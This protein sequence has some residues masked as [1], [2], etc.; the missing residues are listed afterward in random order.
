MTA[1]S[2]SCA[3]PIQYLIQQKPCLMLYGARGVGKS[4]VLNEI[5]PGAVRINLERFDELDRLSEDPAGFLA[6]A[7]GITII[8][9]VHHYPE[10]ADILADFL[11]LLPDCEARFILTSSLEQSCGMFGAKLADHIQVLE[12]GGLHIEETREREPSYFYE[13]L[14]TGNPNDM[15]SLTP[16]EQA[17]HLYHSCLH[18][19]YPKVFTM[20]PDA[21]AEWR[22]EWFRDYVLRDLQT[23]HSG[24]SPRIFFR[25]IRLLASASGQIQNASNL[26]RPLDVSVP[27]VQKYLALAE[28]LMIWRQIPSFPESGGK[29]VVKM[30]RGHLR[31][32]GLLNHFLGIYTPEALHSHVNLRAIW[33]SFIIEQLALGLHNRFIPVKMWHYRTHNQA[34]VDLILEGEFG[35]LPI[36]IKL[37][38]KTKLGK[39]RGLHGFIKEFDCPYGIVINNSKAVGKIADKILEIPATC[40]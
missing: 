34:T 2:R 26:A 27:T 24:V 18:G 33:Q 38:Q 4:F 40:L 14:L 20:T 15:F 12:L 31:D 35:I 9:E 36:V 25:F 16:E 37:G 23:H 5:F 13:L 39:V 22:R 21:A 17:D 32:M 28:D 19:S 1:F 8:E 6:R 3:P 10:L 11:M 29:R 30:P 7:T